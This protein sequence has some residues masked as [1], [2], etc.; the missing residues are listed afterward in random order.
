MVKNSD[1]VLSELAEKSA[2]INKRM[3]NVFDEFEKYGITQKQT[4]KYL[5]Q[6]TT[7][8]KLTK[9]QEKYGM[10]LEEMIDKINKAIVD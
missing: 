8:R 3:T 9:T 6:L 10:T 5:E 4:Q 7:E 1:F 2:L